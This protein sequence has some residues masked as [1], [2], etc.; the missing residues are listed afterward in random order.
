MIK[1]DYLVMSV[2]C[3]GMGAFCYWYN[4]TQVAPSSVKD[5]LQMCQWACF[6]LGGFSL[7]LALSKYWERK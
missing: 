4:Y 1:K 6:L 7:G 2:I 3:F 5:I